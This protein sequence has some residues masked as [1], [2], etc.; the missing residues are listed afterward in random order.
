MQET[1]LIET[2]LAAR[3]AGLLDEV[4][5][6][7]KATLAPGRVERTLETWI[8]SHAISSERRYCEMLEVNGFLEELDVAPLLS[9]AAADTFRRSN[10]L[11]MA[12]AFK[13]E[14]DHFNDVIE[15]LDLQSRNQDENS[16]SGPGR[17]GGVK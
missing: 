11:K 16:G 3:R 15:Y 8:R 2:L 14:P 10:E 12:A 4:W 1:L 9:R 6:E 17:T 5:E 7:I 13:T